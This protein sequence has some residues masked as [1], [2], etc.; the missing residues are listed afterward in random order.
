MYLFAC[1]C[2]KQQQTNQYIDS[3]GDKNMALELNDET[4]DSEVLESE[5]PVLVDFWAPT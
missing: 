5:A 1:I 4:F 3:N 2:Q